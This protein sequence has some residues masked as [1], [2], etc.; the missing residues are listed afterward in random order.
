MIKLSKDISYS[1]AENWN[2]V[3]GNLARGVRSAKLKLRL[4]V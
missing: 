3:F 4:K 1:F 2:P